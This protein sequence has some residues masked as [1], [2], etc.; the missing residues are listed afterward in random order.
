MK[1]LNFLCTVIASFLLSAVTFG[2]STELVPGKTIEKK[3]FKGET[4]RYTISLQKGGYS[5]C[6]VMQE[7]VDLAIDIVD[8]SGKKIITVDGPST[9]PE[10]ISIKPMQ[11]G[12]YELR[13]YPFAGD[14]TATDSLKSALAERN[15]GD[16]AITDFK[17]YSIS[18]NKQRLA[19]IQEDKDLFSQWI[20]SNALEIKTVDAGNGFD[21]LQP[22]KTILKDVRVVGLGEATHG[23]S[24]FF[25]MKHRMVEF[26]V[27]EMGF[28]SFYIEASMSRCRY[29][30][31]YVLNGTGDLDSATAIQGFWTWRVEEV[32]NMIDW[33]RQYN[34]S[35]PD[36]KKVKFLGYDMQVNN[37]AWEGL[38]DFY[39]KVNVKKLI[40]LDSLQT[41][42][43]SALKLVL[44]EF[45][46]RRTDEGKAL[47][48][49]AY[50]QSLVMMD[51]I[52]LNEG[53][54]E[55]LTDNDTYTVNLM[56]IKLIVQEIE[57]FQN[58]L[59][60]AGKLRDHYM[61]EN[62][63]YLLNQ[64]KPNAKVV[65]WAH[66]G[67]IASQSGGMGS[68]LSNILNE[69]Y[70]AVG[71]EFYSGTFQ[72]MNADEIPRKLEA[73]TVGTPPFESLPW[74]FNQ[75]GKEKF[76]ID[77][78]NTDTEK[79]KNFSQPYQMHL[80]GALYGTQY[81]ATQSTSLKDF[82]GMIYIKESTAAKD[83]TKV[84]LK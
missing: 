55:F 44:K 16:Y 30:N 69:A 28:N 63:L 56:N 51:D 12:K 10:P 83:F 60:N 84:V 49:A 37:L 4:H 59:S 47:S 81:P 57:A 70:Y 38:K 33:M 21:D 3:I 6:T 40:E 58:N 54:Y 80:L 78:R 14:S 42:A 34:T 19:K 35:V 52:V 2:Q 71:F 77:F 65:L 20:K 29:I 82:D 76:F 23:T 36:E 67:H 79:I 39:R 62:I 43:Q 74:Y 53:K 5:E 46:S 7:S 73:M 48:K 75:T 41:L 26:L 13:V 45:F 1:S 61:A 66:N 15:Q 25:R 22:L 8:P 68:Y 31:D 27:K 9:G 50:Q 11:T 64:E 24:E 17:K 18:E 72:T 32:R